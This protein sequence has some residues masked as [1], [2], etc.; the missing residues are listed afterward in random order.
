[1]MNRGYDKTPVKTSNGLKIRY[2]KGLI[3][4]QLCPQKREKGL[5]LLV[6][7]RQ[8]FLRFFVTI[9]S[10]GFFFVRVTYTLFI[11]RLCILAFL[12]CMNL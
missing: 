5:L 7:S 4:P 1:M 8:Q 3:C 2:W 9:F 11:H 6:T 12:Y 10:N